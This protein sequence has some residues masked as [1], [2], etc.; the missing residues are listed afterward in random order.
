MPRPKKKSAVLPDAAKRLSGMRSIDPKLN[1]GAGFSNAEF[2]KL[3]DQVTMNLDTY[4]T[5]LSKLAE[6]YTTFEE[7]ERRLAKFSSKM[8]SHVA[9]RYDKDSTQYEMAGGKVRDRRKAPRKT[10]ADRKPMAAAKDA[11]RKETAAV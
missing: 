6:A 10:I 5:L 8:L 1:F 9:I 7:S 11:D 4:N 2:A 3:I